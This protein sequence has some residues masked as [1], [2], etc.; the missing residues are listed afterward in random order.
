MFQQKLDEA[1]SYRTHVQHRLDMDVVTLDELNGTL[2]LLEEL[3]DMENK[4]LLK[5]H[6][7]VWTMLLKILLYIICMSYFN[8]YVS[9]LIF[10]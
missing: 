10:Y 2:H 5:I 6:C 9:N 7:I 1:V 3:G 4:V 8:L